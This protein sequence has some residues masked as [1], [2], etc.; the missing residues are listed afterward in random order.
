[1][2]LAGRGM[3]W[4]EVLWLVGA[5]VAGMLGS[6]VTFAVSKGLKSDDPFAVQLTMWWFAVD[7]LI[8]AK[9]R[10]W[11][12]LFALPAVK[13]DPGSVAT[14]LMFTGIVVAFL[15]LYLTVLD[16]DGGYKNLRSLERPNVLWDNGRVFFG[17]L[18]AGGYAS[19]HLACY[20]GGLLVR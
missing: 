4:H 15:V 12:L 5:S 6:A 13:R 19:A 1:M 14:L 2:L 3:E 7:T 8:G 11:D 20:L 18:L 10:G 17:Q 9:L 16:E